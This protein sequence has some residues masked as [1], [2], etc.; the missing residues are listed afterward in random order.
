MEAGVNCIYPLEAQSGMDAPTLRK[1]YGEQL[2]MIGNI[3]K[4]ALVAGKAVTRRELRSKSSLIDDGGYMPSVDHLVP[5]D[6]SFNKYKY[7]VSLLRKQ[8][9]S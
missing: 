5:P 2:A 3:D 8:L 9:F 1:Q 6:I 4:R 7:Y